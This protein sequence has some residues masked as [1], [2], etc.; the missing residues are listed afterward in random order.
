[1]E[2]L[3]AAIHAD[4]DLPDRLFT[5]ITPD[6]LAATVREPDTDVQTVAPKGVPA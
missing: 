2:R 1:V 5:V 3:R 4:K 6:Q